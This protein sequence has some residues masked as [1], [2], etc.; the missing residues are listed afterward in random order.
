MKRTIR[1]II[2]HCA[3]SQNGKVLRAADVNNSHKTRGF[4]RSSQAVRSFNPE[5]PNIGYHFFIGI[6]GK[7]ETGRGLEEVG[8]HAQGNNSDSIGICMAGT[9]KF[10]TAQWMA[11]RGLVI[12]LA[13]TIKGKAIATC[14]SAMNAYKEM[15]ISVKGH[16]DYSPDLN[17]DGQITRTEWIKVCPGFE[18]SSWIKGGMMPI[19]YA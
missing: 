14:E 9:D 15:G 17:G 13:G 8:A 7:V 5:L 6:D 16:R 11:L 12:E 19:E 10:T 18:V 4:K 1:H 2:I 3:A